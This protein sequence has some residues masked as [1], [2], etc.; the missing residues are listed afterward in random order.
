MV[1]LELSIVERAQAASSGVHRARF[2]AVSHQRRPRLIHVSATESPQ[3]QLSSDP[4]RYIGLALPAIG[5]NRHHAMPE[6][7]MECA[8]DHERLQIEPVRLATAEPRQ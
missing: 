7:L 6:Q 3:R 4:A 2:R 1:E 8:I 5:M